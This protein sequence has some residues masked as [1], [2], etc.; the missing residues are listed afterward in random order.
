MAGFLDAQLSAKTPLF[1]LKLWVLI[2]I[3]VGAFIVLILFF[4]SL[5]LSSRSKKTVSSSKLTSEKTLS[6]S[7]PMVSKEINVDH[8]GEREGP[9]PTYNGYD[10]L[11]SSPR[12]DTEKGKKT[13]WKMVEEEDGI[14][15]RSSRSAEEKG[16]VVMNM[17][18]KSLLN[19]NMSGESHTSANPNPNPNHNP[20]P[21]P[22]SNPN[23]NP[24]HNFNLSPR[25]SP[26]PSYT[27]VSEVTHLGWGHWYSLGDLEA[28]TDFF[29]DSNVLG[30]GGYGI[31]YRGQM[32]DA[33][34]IA[35]KH[36]LNNRSVYVKGGS[37]WSWSS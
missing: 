14:D 9:L 20:N 17:E 37:F 36:L 23:S 28:A 26:S 15:I 22:N 10:D 27:S 34:F 12:S 3:C 16:M 1:G 33:S 8:I 24:N 4:L 2:G 29:S 19:S 35:V 21:N 30:E 18:K 31:V 5:W 13:L 7:I 6:S 25:P 32:P 11:G